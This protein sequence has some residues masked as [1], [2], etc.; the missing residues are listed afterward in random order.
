MFEYKQRYKE[1]SM[2]EQGEVPDYFG[3]YEMKTRG[4]TRTGCIRTVGRAEGDATPK[5]VSGGDAGL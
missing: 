1:Q 3:R 4:Q 5:T 2:K